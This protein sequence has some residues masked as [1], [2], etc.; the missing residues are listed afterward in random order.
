MGDQLAVLADDD[1]DGRVVHVAGVGEPLRLHPAHARLLV[2]QL[3]A[4][5]D[6]VDAAP[7]APARGSITDRQRGKIMALL[8]ELGITQRDNRLAALGRLV[9]RPVASTNHLSKSE[10]HRVIDLL[11]RQTEGARRAPADDPSEVP[12]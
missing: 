4:I 7:M 11:L 5:L 8:A 1:P 10:A 3:T 12:F 2:S 6:T 9:G